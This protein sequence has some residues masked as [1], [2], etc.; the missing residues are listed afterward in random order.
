MWLP[1][2]CSYIKCYL[3]GVAQTHFIFLS[4][5][6]KTKQKK[7]LTAVPTL[8]IARTS[9]ALLSLKRHSQGWCSKPTRYVCSFAERRKLAFCSNS[10]TFLTLISHSGCP[11]SPHRPICF[12]LRTKWECMDTNKKGRTQILKGRTH[13]FAPTLCVIE[14][15]CPDNSW[16]VCT[17]GRG[18]RDAWGI[19][20]DTRRWI[21]YK[22]G[23]TNYGK[24]ETER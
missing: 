3:L 11:V 16:I 8:G 22:L 14:W 19:E 4:W 15:C 2:C 20:A 13:G 6:K 17:G 7:V 1:W 21:N 23:I 5:Y 12:V 24:G 18:H 10:S 9:S